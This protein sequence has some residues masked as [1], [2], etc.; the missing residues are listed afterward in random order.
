MKKQNGFSLRSAAGAAACAMVAVAV[1]CSPPGSSTSATG[2]T[3][4]ETSAPSTLDPQ[5]SALYAD[6][7][8]WQ[9]SYQCL[10][11]T[12]PGGKVEPELATGYQR[13]DDGLTYTF[14]LRPGV[15]FQNGE[16]LT[17]E[18]VAFTFDRLKSSPDGI[19]EELFP[20]FEKAEA[21]SA[22]TVVFHLKRPDAGFLNN[23]ANP[24]VWGCAVMS[25]KAAASE[26]LAT[27]MVGTGPWVQES[28]RPNSELKLKRFDDYW[29]QKTKSE[30]LSVLYVPG[31]ATQVSDLQAGAVDL[32]FTGTSSARTLSG[33]DG[34]EVGT[35]PTDSTIF[36]QINNLTAPFDNLKVRQALALALDRDSLAEHAYSGGGA[37]A[38]LYIPDGES[39]APKPAE[40]PFSTQDTAKAKALLAEAGYP[41]GFST[42]LMYISGYDPGTNDLAAALQDQLAKV[43]IK[44][45]LDPLERGAWVDRLTKAQYPLSWNAQSYYSN[46]YQ[47][48]Q[49]AE[50]RQGAVPAELQ[51]LLD[52]ALRAGDQ[53]A[54]QAALIA[55]EKWEAENV[56]P[57][58]T[59]LATNTVVAYRKGLTGVE[60]PP[61]QSR[62]FLA[63]VSR[64]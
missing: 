15:R 62:T 32:I 8:A 4:A 19:S 47:Y 63:Q 39:W 31:S 37:R 18:D 59:L 56:Y 12:T 54:Y 64:G 6:R 14:D 26:N 13:S 23:M 42:S 34:L 9:L 27:R 51:K 17:A 53:A 29:G 60:L 48:V 43:G 40:V 22:S 46:P 2:I 41:D 55:V 7:F 24:L 61:S 16:T 50:G 57:T 45:K 11:T 10:M 44:V 25:K 49:P 3:V 5:G 36:L 1:G 33:S 21:T 38:S 58:V 20:T 30:R 28:Y 52:D 35:V